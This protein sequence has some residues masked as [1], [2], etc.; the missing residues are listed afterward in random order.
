MADYN[1]IGSWFTPSNAALALSSVY[2]SFSS[3]PQF[4]AQIMQ[5]NAPQGSSVDYYKNIAENYKNDPASYYKDALQWQASTIGHNQ[6]LVD[7][8]GG[9]QNLDPNYSDTSTYK[10]L[11]QEAVDKG[12]FTP[13]QIQDISLDPYQSAY[14]KQ[15]GYNNPDLTGGGGFLNKVLSGI[16]SNPISTLAFPIV[17]ASGL[18]A[19]SA[20]SV[21][22]TDYLGSQALGDAGTGVVGSGSTGFGVNAAAPSIGVDASI[23]ASA[24]TPTELAQGLTNLGAAETTSPWGISA[25]TPTTE[26]GTLNPTVGGIGVDTSA[27]STEPWLGGATTLP[28]GTAGLTADQIA[29]AGTIGNV[30]SNAASGLGYLGGSESLPSGTA[31]IT[32]VTSTPVWDSIS[33]KLSDL[34]NSLSNQQP[35]T[36]GGNT[37]YLLAKGL[38]GGQQETPIGYNMNKNPFSFTAQ[39]PI[40]DT[41]Q[42]Q[43][44]NLL[45]RNQ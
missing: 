38:T 36:S 18:G 14:S 1:A 20:P 35:T 37:A 15:S 23:G 10:K 24:F 16:T 17:A 7:Y 27:L 40:Q 44:A 21:A 30:G 43:L 6:S 26:L 3:A 39:Q 42:Q 8:F 9:A 32:G 33:N 5:A 2:G 29:N 45:K 13:Q 28:E 11:A 4:A 41:T 19:F 34:T 12:Y 31:G 22:G 25:T